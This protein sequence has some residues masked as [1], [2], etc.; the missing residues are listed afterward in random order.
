MYLQLHM[1]FPAAL[2]K[3]NEVKEK[4]KKSRQDVEFLRKE[5]EQAQAKDALDRRNEE[6]DIDSTA[7]KSRS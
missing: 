5:I 2:Q 6:D 1:N 7:S 4:N 3:K